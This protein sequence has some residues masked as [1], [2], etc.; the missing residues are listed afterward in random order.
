MS[1][2]L[3]KGQA[4]CLVLNRMPTKENRKLSRWKIYSFGLTSSYTNESSAM[5]LLVTGAILQQKN[6]F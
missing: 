4:S 5:G 2:K 1:K 3:T 6:P